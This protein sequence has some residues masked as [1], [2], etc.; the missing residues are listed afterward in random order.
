MQTAGGMVLGDS[1]R[2][3]QLYQQ[4]LIVVIATSPLLSSSTLQLYIAGF[5]NGEVIVAIWNVD[6]VIPLAPTVL[7]ESKNDPQCICTIEIK[8]T[9]NGIHPVTSESKYQVQ[10]PNNYGVPHELL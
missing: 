7:C 8:S 2:V 6:F 10:F 4:F 9:R 3:L 1:V 5:S